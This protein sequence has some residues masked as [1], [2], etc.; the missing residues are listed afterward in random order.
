[1]LNPAADE[2]IST[3]P[4]LNQD[5]QTVWLLKAEVETQPTSK[6]QTILTWKFIILSLSFTLVFV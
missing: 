6:L 2:V 1:M 5:L 4:F 3:M